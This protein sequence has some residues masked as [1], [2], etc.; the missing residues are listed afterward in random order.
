[1]ILVC[2]CVCVCIFIKLNIT[3]QS[4]PVILI[5]ICHSPWLGAFNY[6]CYKNL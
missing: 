6:I 4:D 5:I 1:M 3:A 2:V